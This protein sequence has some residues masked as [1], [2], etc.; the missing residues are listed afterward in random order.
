MQKAP[1]NSMLL[2]GDTIF[3]RLV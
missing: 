2:K 3:N 1:T